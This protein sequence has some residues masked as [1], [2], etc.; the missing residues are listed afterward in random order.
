MNP[1]LEAKLERLFATMEAKKAEDQ[2]LS[3]HRYWW[4]EPQ[5][6]QNNKTNETLCNYMKN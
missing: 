1:E 4:Q 2:K 3:R 6:E 5:T